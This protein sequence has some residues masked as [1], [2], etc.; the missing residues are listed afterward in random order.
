MTTKQSNVLTIRVPKD[1]KDRIEKIAYQQGVSMN[2]FAIYA[3]TRE[4]SELESAG[5]FQSQYEN[6]KPKEI[7]AD[8]DAVI[9]QVPKQKKRPE[10]DQLDT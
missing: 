3:F 8:F 7:M 9:A 6:K 2:Q 1:L 4:I 5:F 10:W